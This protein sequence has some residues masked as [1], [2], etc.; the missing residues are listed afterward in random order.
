V[1]RKV[2]RSGPRR[3]RADALPFLLHVLVYPEGDEW[4]A[5]CLEFDTVAQGDSPAEARKGL[6]NALDALIADATEHDDVR[7]L[8]RPAPSG[9]WRKYVD[10]T[11]KGRLRRG[12]RREVSLDDR[13][14]PA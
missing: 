7:S 13:L 4:L 12:T 5:H 3:Q 2:R 9:L 10:A 11:R 8:F 6:D 14:V 1:S